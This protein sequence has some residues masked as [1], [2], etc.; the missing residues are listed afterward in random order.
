M[1]GVHEHGRDKVNM[2][3]LHCPEIVKLRKIQQMASIVKMMDF[4]NFPDAPKN[5]SNNTQ[6][7]GF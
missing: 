2:L 3:T 6:N 5:M 4:G 7:D 1:G